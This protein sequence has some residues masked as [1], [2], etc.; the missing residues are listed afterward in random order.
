MPFIPGTN[1][2]IRDIVEEKYREEVKNK[3]RL[4]EIPELLAY[5]LP[6]DEKYARIRA[7]RENLGMHFVNEKKQA[8]TDAEQRLANGATLE[9][10]LVS[11]M[12]PPWKD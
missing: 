11:F 9:K 1:E 7:I 4:R 6:V 3:Q 2:F 8:F 5:K 12:N 10:K